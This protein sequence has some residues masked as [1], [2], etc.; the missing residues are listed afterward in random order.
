MDGFLENDVD[1]I[2]HAL[3]MI[4]WSFLR[5]LTQVVGIFG[6]QVIKTT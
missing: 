6:T 5:Y 2:A 3:L 1:V 4:T